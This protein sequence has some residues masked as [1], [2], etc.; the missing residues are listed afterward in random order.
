VKDACSAGERELSRIGRRAL[1]GA[2]VGLLAAAALP[3]SVRATT[4]PGVVQAEVIGFSQAGLPLVVYRLGSGGRRVLLLGGQH[5]WPEANTVELAN[6]LL[7]AFAWRQ[8]PLP[9]G[10]GL[11]ALV[12]ANPDGYAAGSRFLASGVDPNRNWGGPDW[13]TDAW[14][15]N[16]SFRAGLGGPEPFSEPETRALAVW[17]LRER[18]AL[19]VN[20]H[21]AGGFLLAEP[22]GWGGRAAA[23]YGT[24]SGY[25]WPEPE[26]D[27]FGYP[28]GGSM[29]IWL[30]TVG[31]PNLFVELHTFTDPEYEA[32]LAGLAA[33]LATFPRP[34]RRRAR[35]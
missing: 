5:G 15:S 22:D 8:P 31:I 7:A 17:C 33:V 35:K 9:A 25:W 23:I 16:G 10:V 14:D 32:H 3:R 26:V 27:P 24:A 28:I 4:E 29:D 30:S 6:L 18:P 1:L 21:S 11:D 34:R 19:V 2:A 13:R 20:Y 12:L